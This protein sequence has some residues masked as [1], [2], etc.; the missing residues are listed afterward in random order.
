MTDIRLPD[1]VREI[2]ERLNA[3]GH[4]ADIVGG[5]TRDFLLGKIPYDYDIT[6]DATP[7]EMYEIFKNYKTVDTGIRHG[8]LTVIIDSEPYEVTTYRLDGEYNDH[9]HPDSV[10]FTELLSEDLSRRD[11]TMN[12]I[13][14]NDRD[15]FTDLFFGTEDIKKR[16]IRT[17]GE[18]ERRF[19]EDALR[20]L[21]G[22]RF[23]ATL[24]FTIEA[25]TA[26]ALRSKAE[27]LLAVSPERVCA[28]WK[29]LIGGSA[30]H[31]VI[32]EYNDVIAVV[33]PELS[34][35]SF[36]DAEAFYSQSANLRELALFYLIHKER[37]A[38]AYD[39]AARRLRYDNK[40]R[41][42]GCTVL[43]NL[44]ICDMHTDI[45]LKT[46]LMRIGCEYADGVVRLAAM[47]SLCKKSAILRLEYLSKESVWQLSELALNGKDL[48]S[49]GIRGEE[50]GRILNELLSMV[51]R[52]SCANEKKELLSIAE[53]LKGEKNG[54]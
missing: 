40:S 2:I 9:R 20:I 38:Q 35:A 4:R 49:L 22:I 41:K 48:I 1:S 12:A 44:T 7:D 30:A 31:R 29:K 3:S 5:C 6:T 18:P 21:R 51:V 24:D 15:G 14:Y 45:G 34:N 46:L 50:V 19:E 32:S 53:Q 28:E 47:L 27:L 11:F 16:I 39:T 8:T 43:E 10:I 26:K 54:V 42:Y 25:N 23:A 52:D 33:I 37:A 36:P 17:V 13:C